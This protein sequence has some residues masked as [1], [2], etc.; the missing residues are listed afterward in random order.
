M[1]SSAVM[2]EGEVLVGPGRQDPRRLGIE[3]PGLSRGRGVEHSLLC[4]V[5]ETQKAAPS[6]GS[7]LSLALSPP[8]GRALLP[9]QF[10]ISEPPVPGSWPFSEPIPKG[11]WRRVDSGPV[12]A[13]PHFQLGPAR[14]H[15]NA[16]SHQS[17][18]GLCSRPPGR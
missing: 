4:N 12:P 2:H 8:Q 10:T 15:S 5:Q 18:S 14:L 1:H 17:P 11:I 6:P 13:R 3:D 9:P 16:E 7:A